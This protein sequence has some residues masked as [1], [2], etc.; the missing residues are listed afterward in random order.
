MKIDRLAL[1]A[2]LQE[3]VGPQVKVAVKLDK[4]APCR[5]RTD[6]RDKTIKVTLNPSK[7]KT[8][9]SVDRVKNQLYEGISLT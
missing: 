9:N 1:Q 5:S 6:F 8:P 7:I 3:F 2:E 4:R